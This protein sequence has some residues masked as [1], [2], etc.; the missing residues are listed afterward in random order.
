MLMQFFKA[1]KERKQAELARQAAEIP[2]SIAAAEGIADIGERVLKLDDINN[3]LQQ[4]QTLLFSKYR[5]GF[6][7]T[8]AEGLKFIGGAMAG[9][10]VGIGIV[11]LAGWPAAPIAIAFVGTGA[12]SLTT[13]LT[14]KGIKDRLEPAI[15]HRHHERHKDVYNALNAGMIKI[16]QLKKPLL[17]Q[18]LEAF[19][20]SKAFDAVQT[21][22]PNLRAAFAAKAIMAL[23]RQARTGQQHGLLSFGP[24]PLNP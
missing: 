21:R 4:Q 16:H 22:F 19:A 20:S 1:R 18:G 5:N 3:K 17:D 10:A 11:F 24:R 23:R 7:S 6:S 15:W 8:L 9:Y 2:L 14:M 12:G 13:F